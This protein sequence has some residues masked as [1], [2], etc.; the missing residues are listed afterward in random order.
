MALGMSQNFGSIAKANIQWPPLFEEIWA[1]LSQFSFEFNFFKPECSAKVGYWRRWL[2]F[3]SMMYLFAVPFFFSY[4]ISK[5]F[6]LGKIEDMNYVKNMLLRN[7]FLRAL[8][9]CLLVMI[10]MHFKQITSPFVCIPPASGI[11][12]GRMK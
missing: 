12:P 6:V 8:A 7:A 5:H 4:L 2:F 3:S 9:T 11:G 10:P 1:F